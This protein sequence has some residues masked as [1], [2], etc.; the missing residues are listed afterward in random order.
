MYS[1]CP[2]TYTL[3]QGNDPSNSNYTGIQEYEAGTSVTSSRIVTGGAGTDVTY[4]GGTFVDLQ[5]GFHAQEDNLFV[6]RTG[7]CG[8]T[9]PGAP[10]QAPQPVQ[11]INLTGTYVGSASALQS[12][13]P[14]SSNVQVKSSQ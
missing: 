12:M 5:A 1:S 3:T 14:G 4:Q 10:P 8:A 7:P 11:K 13:L 6:A 2:P 9:A